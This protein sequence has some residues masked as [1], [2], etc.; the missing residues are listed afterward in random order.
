MAKVSAPLL[1]I[2]GSGTI[3]KSITFAS[4]KGIKYAR[5][6]VIPANPQTVG[7]VSTRSVFTNGGNIWKLGSD[8]LTAPWNRFAQGQPLT[9]R[10]KFMGDFVA[11]LRGQADLSLMIFSPGAKGGTPANSIIVTPVSGGLDV[12]FDAPAPPTGWT[13]TRALACAIVDGD[14]ETI[15]DFTTVVN[16]DTAV[17]GTVTLTGLEVGT[18]YQVGAWLEWAK[19]DASVSYGPSI[20]GTGTPIA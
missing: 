14:P 16:D 12:V 7:Q 2:G 19:P 1:S 18:P 11:R 6:R 10:N 15:T 17:P 9:G 8:L 4:W 13:L 20:N 3:G 5:A